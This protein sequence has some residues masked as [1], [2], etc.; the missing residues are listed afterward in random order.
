MKKTLLFS[1]ALLDLTSSLALAGGVNFAWNDCIGNT[2]SAPNKN[3]VN[4]ATTTSTATDAAAGS[5]MLDNPIPDF[6]ALE[7]TI[8]LQAEAVSL[9]AWWDF[10][11]CHNGSLA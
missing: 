6:D 5:F 2:G 11:V 3:F 1:G 4:C 8:D 9:P 7:I 10:N